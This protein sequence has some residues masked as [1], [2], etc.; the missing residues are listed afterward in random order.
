MYSYSAIPKRIRLVGILRWACNIQT[1]VIV[2]AEYVNHADVLTY[3]AIAR[4]AS[5]PR[6]T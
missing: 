5:G 2:A 6:G 4:S 1:L 3:A